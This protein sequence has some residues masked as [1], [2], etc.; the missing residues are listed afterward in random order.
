MAKLNLKKRWEEAGLTDD[1]IFSKVFLDPQ[2]TLELLRRI[3]PE[4][5]IKDI[6]VLN[7][8][9]E[10]KST[11]DA[12]SVRFDIYIEDRDNNHYDIEMQV[13]DHHNLPQRNRFYQA[14]LSTTAYTKGQ[15]YSQADNTFVIFFCCFDPF[16]L[17]EQR[18]KVKRGI[19]AYPN[20]PYRD[21]EQTLFFDITSL[22]KTVGPKLKHVLDL[23]A[24][25]KLDE[26]DDFIIKLRQRICFVKQNRKW[27]KEYMQRSLYEM[28]IENERNEAVRE[29]HELGRQQGLKEGRHEGHEQGLEQGL[30]EGR[31]QGR[32]DG[33]KEGQAKERL[34]LVTDLIQSGQN[35]AQ[36]ENFLINIRKMDPSQATQYYQEALRLLK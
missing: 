1:F 22:Q 13:A 23:L 4:L 10:I 33:R 32:E 16:G 19:E 9:Q 8:Q 14:S 34:S 18:Y 15:N 7:S 2:I 30:K 12:K 5:V 21:S 31:E 27:R 36:V 35:Q 11:Y 20:Y 26:D 24:N 25:R 28:D 29:G 17:G 6:K 3:F